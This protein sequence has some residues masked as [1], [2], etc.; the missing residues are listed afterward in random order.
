MKVRLH[1]EA[2]AEALEAKYY[3]REDDPREA[4]AFVVELQAAI[5]RIRENPETPACFSGEYRKMRAGKFRYAAVYRLREGEIQVMAVMH[6]HR[7]PGYWKERRF[8]R[9]EHEA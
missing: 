5:D 9:P 6:L 4:E 7:K 2:L 3:I 1:P 8:D